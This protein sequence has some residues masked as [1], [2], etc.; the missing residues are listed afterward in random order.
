MSKESV[1]LAYSRGTSGLTNIPLIN[2]L[3]VEFD[4]L[5]EIKE[6]LYSVNQKLPDN[7]S[8]NLRL[9]I[10]FFL[11]F[12]CLGLVILLNV[13]YFPIGLAFIPF[14]V[15]PYCIIINPVFLRLNSSEL[16]LHDGMVAID[17]ISGSLIRL[18]Y[19]RNRK[20]K[21]LESITLKIDKTLKK[22]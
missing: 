6:V 1:T 22:G 9:C 15:I 5:N 10:L 19:V 14:V 18:T 17:R 12:P 8:C 2:D 13:L 7:K 4:T 3:D 20:T 11:M 21:F 16:I